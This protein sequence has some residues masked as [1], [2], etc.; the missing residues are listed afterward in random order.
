M[1]DKCVGVVLIPHTDLF[2]GS[3][4]SK[5]RLYVRGRQDTVRKPGA[6]ADNNDEP[7]EVSTIRILVLGLHMSIHCPSYRNSLFR[8]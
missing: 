5:V 6:A 8:I 4:A 2:P 1:P 3:V 7:F